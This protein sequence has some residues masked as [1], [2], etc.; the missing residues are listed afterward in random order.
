LRVG[1]IDPL[2]VGHTELVH[3]GV[4]RR[5]QVRV[6]VRCIGQVIVLRPVELVPVGGELRCLVLAHAPQGL[7]LH[8]REQALVD[9]YHVGAVGQLVVLVVQVVC[10]VHAIVVQ[11]VFVWV[12]QWIIRQ[13]ERVDVA[14]LGDVVVKHQKVGAE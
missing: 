9:F 8:V 12:G 10:S 13:E 4:V 11:V 3:F 7:Q 2:P 6:D 14:L 5:G 1:R